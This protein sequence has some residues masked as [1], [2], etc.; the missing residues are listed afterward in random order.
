MKNNICSNGDCDNE[1]Q[2]N[3]NLNL[4][5]Q[6]EVNKTH[7]N[8]KVIFISIVGLML[9]LF[10]I[11]I[12]SKEPFFANFGGFV[13]GIVSP[14]V[15]L[16]GVIL[17]YDTLALQRKELKEAREQFRKSSAA[18]ERQTELQQFQAECKDLYL[19]FIPHY[20]N[21][22]YLIEHLPEFEVHLNDHRF[23]GRI[24]VSGRDFFFTFVTDK[25]NVEEDAIESYLIKHK[26][27]LD[28]LDKR[29]RQLISISKLYNGI[30]KPEFLSH[31]YIVHPKINLKMVEVFP[32]A[33]LFYK[34]KY[35]SAL[36][37]AYFKLIPVDHLNL[38][39]AETD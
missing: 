37:F 35:F 31:K 13:G 1:L 17:L 3:S 33:D 38:S 14:L 2:P 23:K 6:C 28:E 27:W 5:S 20:E 7:T 12:I 26:G 22:I 11:Y 32:I 15:A 36:D 25:K 9:V 39:R 8:K 4:C 16:A 30:K 29:L 10:V 18:L 34:L 21:F 19:S 24:N